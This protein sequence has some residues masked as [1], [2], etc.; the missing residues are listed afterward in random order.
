MTAWLP[1]KLAGVWLGILYVDVY[2]RVE[3]SQPYFTVV[4]KPAEPFKFFSGNKQTHLLEL[5]RPTLL[6]PTRKIN[7]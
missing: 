6:S 5:I 2:T 7:K 4:H 3:I 1:V